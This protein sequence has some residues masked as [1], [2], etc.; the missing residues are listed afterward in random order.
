M[1]N[2]EETYCPGAAL[3]LY[4]WP[5]PAPPTSIEPTYR[6]GRPKRT[7]LIERYNES[8]A[9]RVTLPSTPPAVSIILEKRLA[10]S[11]SR[12]PHVWTALVQGGISHA[13]TSVAATMTE[14]KYPPLLVAKI[15]DPVFFDDE[16]TLWTDPF[17][18][19]DHSLAAE[20]ESYRRLAPLQ[21]TKVPRFYG[22][23]AAVLPGQNSRTV[24]IILIELVPGRDVSAIVPPD[25]T[26]NL[27]A[28]HKISIVNASL[29][30]FFDILA[31]GVRQYDMKSRN[32]ILR[33]QAH[34]PSLIQGTRFCDT[35]ECTLAFEVDCNNLDL[36]MVDFEF[37]E[38]KEPDPSL[39]EDSV[40]RRHIERAQPKYLKRWLENAMV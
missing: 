24:Y 40:K 35:E 3:D 27:C 36:V 33:P 34:V 20:V 39:S 38:F 15:F 12:V 7:E 23:F 21:G 2:L 6:D 13:L 28:K 8:I 10:S 29:G 25:A 30:L 5:H 11:M 16:E 32:V 17:A 18:I 4:A 26:E 9:E 19:R 1:P 37:V 22:F 31:C 14:A